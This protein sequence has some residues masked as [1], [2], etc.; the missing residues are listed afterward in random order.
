MEERKE[1]EEDHYRWPRLSH[2]GLDAIFDCSDED[3]CAQ[4]MGS[5]RHTGD[6]DGE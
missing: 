4:D 5:L 1:T 6:L 3:E 2:H